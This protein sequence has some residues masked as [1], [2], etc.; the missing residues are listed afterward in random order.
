MEFGN[1]FV[2]GLYKIRSEKQGS[3]RK[4]LFCIDGNKLI[5]IQPFVKN[6]IVFSSLYVYLQ[7]HSCIKIVFVIK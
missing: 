7:L 5:T 6:G 4:C 2:F 1:F 3:V